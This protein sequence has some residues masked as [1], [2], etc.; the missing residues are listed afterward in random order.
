MQKTKRAQRWNVLLLIVAMTV[1]MGQASSQ[2]SSGQASLD[3]HLR[4]SLA[5]EGEQ[6]RRS[7]VAPA[8][9]AEPAH[10][11]YTANLEDGSDFIDP[12]RFPAR[13]PAERPVPSSKFQVPSSKTPEESAIIPGRAVRLEPLGA[14]T[15]STSGRI[16]FAAT[17]VNIQTDDWRVIG[18]LYVTKGDGTTEKLFGPRAIRLGR[19]QTLRLPIGFTANPKRFP[20][21]P[22]RFIA[23]LKD[24]TGQIVDRAV[25]TFTLERGP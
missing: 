10:S 19:A 16:E 15:I 24:Q 20:P 25:L 9:L 5:G 22:T 8:N 21:G 12:L 1:M 13:P 23:V 6:S 4:Q 2:T 3:V 7:L 11:S 14:L 18:E 17:L